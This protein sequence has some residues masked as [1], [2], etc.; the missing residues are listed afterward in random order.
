MDNTRSLYFISGAFFFFNILAEE[1]IQL[2]VLGNA[3]GLGSDT[4]FF[5]TRSINK[6]AKDFVLNTQKHIFFGL[7][8]RLFVC[9]WH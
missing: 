8:V 3:A 7:F 4:L 1:E 5:V 6:T 2:Y 9:F